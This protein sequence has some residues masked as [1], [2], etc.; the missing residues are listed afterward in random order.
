MVSSFRS[1]QHKSLMMLVSTTWEVWAL[2]VWGKFDMGEWRVMEEV[3]QWNLLASHE[4]LQRDELSLGVIRF[5]FGH[6]PRLSCLPFL[7]AQHARKAFIHTSTQSISNSQNNDCGS[8]A[9][10]SQPSQLNNRHSSTDNGEHV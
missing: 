5:E 1:G 2:F 7:T 8:S 4:P 10:A 6:E 9:G 3:Q